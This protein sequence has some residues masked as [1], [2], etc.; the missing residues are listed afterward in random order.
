[1]LLTAYK[2]IHAITAVDVVAKKFTIAGDKT[3]LYL[4]GGSLTVAGST[5]NDGAYTVASNSTL[6]A[7]DTEIVVNEV[8]PSAVADGNLELVVGNDITQWERDDLGGNDPLKWETTISSGYVDITTISNIDTWYIGAGA[9]YK[10]MRN[11]LISRYVPSWG[12]LTTIEKQTLVRHFVWDSTETT[13]NLDLL[14]TQAERDD[15]QKKTMELLDA[16]CEAVIRRSNVSGSIKYFDHQTD[17][18]GTLTTVEITTDV[19]LA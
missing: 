12:T 8:V 6:V 5:G 16:T 17:D 13:E 9:S 7:S 11:E 19:E 14:Y 2:I 15:Y 3:N 4:S 1:M 18:V 10:D